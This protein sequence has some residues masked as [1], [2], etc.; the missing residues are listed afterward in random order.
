MPKRSRRVFEYEYTSGLLHRYRETLHKVCRRKFK[1]LGG[2]ATFE[3]AAERLSSGYDM[4][5]TPRLEPQGRYRA[6]LNG[7]K[8]RLTIVGIALSPEFIY[9]LGPGDLIPD[10]R[11]FGIIWMGERAAEAAFDLDGAF[12]SIVA[13]L[14]RSAEPGAV[15]DKVDK[16]L[17]RYGGTGAYL[18]V[19]QL[20]HAFIDA[21]LNQLRTMSRIIPPIFFA[22]AAFLIN[23][24]LSRLIVRER[25][26]IGDMS[27]E[28]AR[29]CCPPGPAVPPAVI[30]AERQPLQPARR[31]S[32]RIVSIHRS[33]DEDHTRVVVLAVVMRNEQ[34]RLGGSAHEKARP[35]DPNSP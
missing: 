12:N 18:R 27:A 10:D 2:I 23:M 14:E 26:Q 3:I 19:D 30:D 22:V 17:D 11:R 33:V 15:I 1:E 13:R 9:A 21:E 29:H 6:V 4:R 28:V 31:A 16:V 34:L 8:K 20:S 25:E 24:A 35:N 7:R 5:A 32:K